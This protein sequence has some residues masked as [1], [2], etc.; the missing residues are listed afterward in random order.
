MKKTI[1]SGA[2]LAL[3]LV[4]FPV[5]SARAT[6]CDD[7]FIYWEYGGPTGLLVGMDTETPASYTIFYTSNGT[8]P[9]HN[10]GNPGTGTSIFY[11][12]IPIPYG[13]WRYFRA[14][15]YKSGYEDSNMAAE[16][17]SNPV[18]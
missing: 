5:A 6:Q 3:A 8:T 1:L 10:A 11:G 15:C 18:Q 12:D 7:V 13:Q 17:I 2:L 4:V 9:T 16:D 14:I